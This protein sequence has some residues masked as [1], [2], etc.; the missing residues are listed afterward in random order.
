MN[1]NGLTQE[2]MK[3]YAD[4]LKMANTQQL[5]FMLRSLQQELQARA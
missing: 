2:H 1:N 3:L 5:F 4:L